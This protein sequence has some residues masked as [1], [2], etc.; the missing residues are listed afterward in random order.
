MSADGAAGRQRPPLGRED[1]VHVAELARLALTDEEVARFTG[2]LAQVLAHAADVAALDLSK[3][4]PTAH[5]LPL[6]NVLRPDVEVPGLPREDVL[7]AA[8]TV[9]DHR[10]KVP[11]ITGEAP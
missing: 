7:A 9:E 11:R 1:V 6:R 4:A 8:P 5:P 10:F 3:V 2:Q